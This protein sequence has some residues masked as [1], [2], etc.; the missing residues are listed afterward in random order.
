MNI[1]QAFDGPFAGWLGDPTDWQPWR[2]FLKTLAAVPLSPAERPLFER[3]TGRT[4]EFTEPVHEAWVVVGRRGRKSAIAAVLGVHA[5]VHVDWSSVIAPGETARVIIVAVDKGQAKIVR[6]YCEAILRSH[7]D[8]EA[9]IAGTDAESVT[10]ANGIQI[11]CVA[12]SF[13]SIRGPAVVCA[14]FEECAFWRSDESATPDR[15]VLRAVRPAML[16]TKRHGALMIG[17]SSPYAKKG[18]LYEKHRA[19]FGHDDS[20]I[21]VWQADTQTMNPAVDREEIDEA[22]R[23]DP[24]AAAAEYGALFRDDISNFLDADLLATLTRDQPLELPPRDGIRYVAFTDPSGG[25]G[26]AYTLGIAHREPDGRAVLDVVRT[27]Q[28]PLDPALVTAEYAALLK[29]YRLRE[30]TGDAYSGAWVR[31]AF[32]EHGIKYKVSSLPKSA[33]YLECLPLFARGE[34]ELPDLR[35]LLVELAQLERR[36]ARGGKDSVDHPPRCH[37]DLANAAAGALVLA[38]VEKKKV[39]IFAVPVMWSPSRSNPDAAYHVPD[40]DFHGGGEVDPPSGCA[41]VRFDLFNDDQGMRDDDN[42]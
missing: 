29:E 2:T 37:D 22:Y 6:S 31:D 16:T 12:N 32:D 41:G 4:A 36:T 27:T 23:D 20:R 33:I 30:V 34:V 25:R 17:I 5:A 19:H 9:L 14:I 28:A 3:C 21:L 15:E 13:R 7:P 8:L 40:L 38:A 11:Q 24:T 18:L 1:V 39:P 35:P 42:F 26:D 10:L